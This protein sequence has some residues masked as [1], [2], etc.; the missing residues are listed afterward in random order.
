[1]ITTMVAADWPPVAAIYREGIATGHATFAT[2]PPATW[3]EW[4]KNKINSCSVVAKENQKI[5][6][7]AA[8]SPT[9][10]RA[11]YAGVA[12]VSIYVSANARGQ[13][14]GSRLLPELI[15]TSEANGIWTLQAGI[16]PE[17]Q[18]SL[19]LHFKHGFRQVGIREKMGKMEFGPYQ[20]RWRDVVLLERR[21]KISG[22]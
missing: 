12:D 19:S 8:L 2:Q 5:L 11:V 10:T 1:M 6:G 16:F 7:W 3:E 21:S 15:R 20:G 18:A 22:A 17:N 9:S 13:G 4:C 14:V